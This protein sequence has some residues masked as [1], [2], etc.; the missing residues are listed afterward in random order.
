MPSEREKELIFK[1]KAVKEA[2][3]YFKNV[4]M[5][6][7]QHKIFLGIVG[8]FLQHIPINEMALKGIG[9]R[10]VSEWQLKHKRDILGLENETPE[11]RVN[12]IEKILNIVKRL[13]TEILEDPG[14][15]SILDD[16]IMK[17]MEFYKK[18]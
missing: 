7:E 15:K 16:V 5:T 2:E 10:G 8:I 17:A 3:D 6:Q 18:E 9:W 1:P 13:L 12:S 11:E 14:Q 4:H